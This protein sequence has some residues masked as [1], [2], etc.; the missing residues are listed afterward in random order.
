MKRLLAV[1]SVLLLLQACVGFYGQAIRGQW[2]LIR[3]PKP[4][5]QWLATPT[6]DEA[7]R[8]N[9]EIAQSAREF[10]IQSLG[11]PDNK[12]YTRYADL[13]RPFVVWSVVATPRYSL[14]PKTWCFP[15]A[16]CVS[17][18]GYF[19]KENA[20]KFARKLEQQGYDVS[21]GGVPAYSTLG[22]LKDPLLNTMFR[23]GK[24]SAVS[25][26]FHE[27]AHQKIYVKGDTPF[28]E[29]FAGA[30]EEEGM[31]RWIE[32][33]EQAEET[34]KQYRENRKRRADFL[35][36]VSDTQTRLR[37]LYARELDETDKQRLKAQELAQLKENYQV[38]R[39]KWGGRAGYDAWFDR[40]LNN[41]H[42]AS[43]AT[44]EDLLPAFRIILRQ[45]KNDLERFYARVSELAE[46]SQEERT[47]TMQQ[48]LALSTTDVRR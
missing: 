6:T 32:R 39:Q 28:N 14:Q 18:R 21:V 13:E 20:E 25:T 36:I 23:Y 48:L 17:Y 47:S 46:L 16:G 42:I 27:L 12:S 15:I 3:K 2:E 45:E 41:A 37:S 7:L 43:V 1:L 4:I 31:R 38:M 35:R 44:Y 8:E 26:I 29:A 34:L 30:V 22:R 40:P 5:E 9:L 33:Q 24:Q 10:A 19:K 11:L